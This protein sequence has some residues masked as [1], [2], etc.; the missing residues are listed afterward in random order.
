MVRGIKK[1][2]SVCVREKKREG[3]R[4]T[5]RDGGTEIE[6][7]THR[8]SDCDIEWGRKGRE[9]ERREHGMPLCL[10]HLYYLYIRDGMNQ[11]SQRVILTR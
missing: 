8:R 5:D 9:C 2:K 7:E 10:L 11:R 6:T 4:K 1:I 3:E